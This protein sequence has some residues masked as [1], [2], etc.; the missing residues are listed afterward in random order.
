M[1]NNLLEGVRRWLEPLPDRS[2]P[3]LNIQ[4]FL[5]EQL[6]KMYID[7]NS[8]KE[9]GLGRIV[10]F[11]TK[12]RRVTTPIVRMAND[13]VAAWSRPIIKRSSSYRD[14]MIPMAPS[15]DELLIQKAQQPARLNAILAKMREEDAR[16]V[17]RNAVQIPIPVMKTFTVAPRESLSMQKSNASVVNDIERRRRA[18]ERMRSMMRKM[19]SKN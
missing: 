12:C 14:R 18:Q 13:L 6:T 17:R 7:T 2:L 8:L 3:A 15:N 19:S 11:Y 1:D 16:R 10:L 4:M 9:S 5:F